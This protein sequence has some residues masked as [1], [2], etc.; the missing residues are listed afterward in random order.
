MYKPDEEKWLKMYEYA[1][2]YYLEHHD[3]AV[4]S[5]YCFV[6]NGKK[7]TL[8]TWVMMQK[9]AYYKG[10]MS[11]TR[12]K[13]LSDIGMV[14]EK[15]RTNS[16]TNDDKWLEIYKYAILFY[17]EY[18]NIKVSYDYK[19]TINGCEQVN[20][21]SWVYRQKVYYSEGKLNEEKIRLLNNLRIEWEIP[22]R[23]RDKITGI[24][25]K[26]LEMYNL[27]LDYYKSHENT[28]IPWNYVVIKDG[29]TID[30]GTWLRVEKSHFYNGKLS[31]EK[32]ILLNNLGINENTNA[33]N[34]WEE[35]KKEWYIMYKYALE[36]FKEHGNI[37]VSDKFI[38]NAKDNKK[39]ELGK[40]I[41]NQRTYYKRGSLLIERKELLEE[42][43]IIWN[44]IPKY[45]EQN[46][47][48]WLEMYKCAVLYYKEH[49][50]LLIPTEYKMTNENDEVVYLGRWLKHQRNLYTNNK[51]SKD[52]IEM[53]ESIGII[54]T[55]LKKGP[56]TVNKIY[57]EWFKYYE[58]VLKYYQEYGYINAS[59]NF[60]I[61]IDEETLE[62]ATWLKVQMFNYLRNNLRQEQIRLLKEIEFEKYISV[63]KKALK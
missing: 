5:K 40:W 33:V 51:L 1:K 23:K 11:E 56:K 28:L 52:K 54:W 58:V 10:K 30:L 18:G 38:Y 48:K 50:D 2:E 17:K 59:E 6:D 7:I 37:D 24:S 39:V 14:W 63:K 8:G 49:G 34:K 3:L 15:K 25:E 27:I 32:K 22:K 45:P 55:K 41:N 60:K 9:V 29:K 13:M 4:P 42:I 46:L 21:K 43:G 31:E 12:Y 20:L 19:V 16:L 47:K 61:T 35:K 57:K 44:R 36:Y 26:W 62:V 53:L